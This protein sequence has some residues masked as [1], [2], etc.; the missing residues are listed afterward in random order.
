[1]RRKKKFLQ[2]Q[3]NWRA[4]NSGTRRFRKWPPAVRVYFCMRPATVYLIAADLSLIRSWSHFANV[5][6]MA[7]NVCA[8]QNFLRIGWT[9]WT[10]C[11][12]DY[13]TETFHSII[14]VAWQ[15]MAIRR[16][17]VKCITS[18]VL[19]NFGFGMCPLQSMTDFECCVP[20]AGVEVWSKVGW[21]CSLWR[22][23]ATKKINQSF[24]F[25]IRARSLRN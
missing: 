6:R 20:N 1:M 17:F 25:M 23:W 21:E 22:R 19:A 15:E 3:P 11:R 12:T 24:F 13:G 5:W 4:L 14:W 18:H 10:N 9:S 7:M 16:G 2:H 8:K